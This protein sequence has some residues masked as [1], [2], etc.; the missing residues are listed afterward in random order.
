MP[1]ALLI[2]NPASVLMV[3]SENKLQSTPWAL[4]PYYLQRATSIP[5]LP[6]LSVDFPPQLTQSEKLSQ[7]HPEICFPSDSKPRQTDKQD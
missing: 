7:T 3:T 6:G 2:F 4:S 5:V 1:L